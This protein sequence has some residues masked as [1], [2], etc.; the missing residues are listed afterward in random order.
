[1]S[2]LGLS[3]VRNAASLQE[4]PLAATGSFPRLPPSPSRAASTS[5][6]GLGVKLGVDDNGAPIIRQKSLDVR[7]RPRSLA[8]FSTPEKDEAEKSP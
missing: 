6:M 8:F 4:I 2:A 5:D 7:G 3:G 1:M